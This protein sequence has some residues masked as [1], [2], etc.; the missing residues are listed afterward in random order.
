MRDALVADLDFG[1]DVAGVEVVE[2]Y[3]G[4]EMGGLA[5]DEGVGEDSAFALVLLDDHD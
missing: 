4:A 1:D 5:L 2:D 3:V